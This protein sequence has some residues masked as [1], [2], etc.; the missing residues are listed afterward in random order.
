MF[1][2]EIPLNVKKIIENNSLDLNRQPNLPK[3]K[4]KKKFKQYIEN[5]CQKDIAENHSK[6]LVLVKNQ[7]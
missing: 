5:K 1:I 7:N 4:D 2:S 3:H 6:T